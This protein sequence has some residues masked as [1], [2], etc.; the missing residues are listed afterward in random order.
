M[1]WRKY[2]IASLHTAPHHIVIVRSAMKQRYFGRSAAAVHGDHKRRLMLQTFW[3]NVEAFRM[4]ARQNR[5]LYAVVGSNRVFA[6]LYE[7][8]SAKIRRTGRRITYRLAKRLFE[9]L[10]GGG[11]CGG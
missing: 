8:G 1:L 5:Y 9:L 10:G 6:D 4:H 2:N 7:R 11:V 3:H